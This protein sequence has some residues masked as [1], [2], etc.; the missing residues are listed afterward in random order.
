MCSGRFDPQFVLHALETG[1][2]DGVMVVG[3]HPGDCHYVDGNIK[4]E[5]R[6]KMT[7]KL[8]DAVGV[9][10]DRLRL[11]WVSASEGTKFQ[12]VVTDFTNQIK[13]LGPNPLRKDVKAV[14]VKAIAE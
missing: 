9:S 11:E 2:V 8:L 12:N 3:C 4:A 10:S 5:K 14:E 6:V 1:G 13:K 7:A